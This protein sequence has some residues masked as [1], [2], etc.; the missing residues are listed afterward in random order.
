MGIRG[1]QAD[2]LLQHRGDAERPHVVGHRA[3]GALYPVLLLHPMPT[4]L[5][6]ARA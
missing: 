5:S 6:H 2:R 4:H 3:Q 1:L